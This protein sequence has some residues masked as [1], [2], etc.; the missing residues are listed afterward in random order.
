MM[1]KKV[2]IKKLM[3]LLNICRNH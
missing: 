1:I 3:M 2:K